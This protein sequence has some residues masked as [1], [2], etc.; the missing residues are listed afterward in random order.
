M[1]KISFLGDI[2][3][4]NCYNFFHDNNINPFSGIDDILRK[5]DFN[6]GNLECL[7]KGNEGE[8]KLKHP[9]LNTRVE[10]LNL[11]KYLNLGIVSLAHNHIY[12]NLLD[13]FNKTVEQLDSQ[14]IQYLGAGLSP[15]EAKRELI[16]IEND[17]SLGLL[18]FVS[19]NTNPQLPKNTNVFLNYFDISDVEKHIKDLKPKVDHLIVLLHWG[20]KVEE[21]FYP[22]FKQPYFAKRIID[23]GAD[24]II[25]GHPHTV[26]PFEIYKDKYIFYSLGNF[27]FDDIIVGDE[28]FQ[29]GKYR[30]RKTIIPTVTFSKKKYTV[31]IHHAKNLDGFIIVNNSLFTK[32]KMLKRNFLFK[33]IKNKKFIW[34]FYYWH[35]KKIV[36]IKMYFIEANEGVINRII[37]LDFKRVIRYILK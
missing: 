23:S 27:C 10:T 30:K 35:L 15:G 19:Q 13:G 25:G 20:G 22:D 17:I 32:L 18:N 29:I 34:N 24:L 28:V 9:R 8:N 26:Q 14:K 16:I 33:L 21:G 31:K 5:S 4:N 12:D 36:P 2:S 11:L 3:F 1:V 6:I 37:T 7:A